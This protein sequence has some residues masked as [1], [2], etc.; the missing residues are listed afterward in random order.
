[1]FEGAL[2]QRAEHDAGANILLAQWTFDRQLIGAALQSVQ[3]AYGHYSRHDDSHSNA[4]L[5]QIGRLLGPKRLE[6]LSATDL[7]LLLE[8]AYSHDLGMVVPDAEARAWWSSSD[9][10]LYL[11]TLRSHSDPEYRRA[12]EN[13][14]NLPD[15]V[16]LGAE[17]PFELKRALQL[18]IAE[19]GRRRHA[20]RSSD[21]VVDPSSIGLDSPRALIP[22]RL[23]RVLGR[24]CALHGASLEE[25]M[26]LVQ[27]EQGIG[28]DDAHPRFV[29]C[30]LRIGDLLDV[31]DGRFC[32]VM[33]AT[34]GALPPSSDAHR[35]KH[36]AI[37]HLAV[38]PTRIDVEAV[39]EAGDEAAYDEAERWFAWLADEA[40]TL[41]ARWTEIS[42]R[43]S[44]GAFPSVGRVEAR[45]AQQVLVGNRRPRLEVD[46]ESLLKLM[47]G[48]N[49][50]SDRWDCI[51]ELLQ[52]AVDAVLLRVWE[53]RREDVERIASLV[54]S[55]PGT[56]PISELA[57]LVR[58]SAV[59]IEVRALPRTDGRD[60]E[61]RIW[62]VTVVDSGSGISARD[63][64]FIQRIGGSAKNPARLQARL[65][66]PEWIQPSGIFGIGLQSVFLLSD[67]ITLTSRALDESDVRRIVIRKEAS[68]TAAGVAVSLLDE[69]EL[70]LGAN[71]KLR[72][73]G[74]TR[75]EF[76][77]EMPAVPSTVS[78]SSGDREV[79]STLAD[80]DPVASDSLPYGAAKIRDAVRR[81]ARH[82]LVPIRL[83]ARDCPR[84]EEGKSPDAGFRYFDAPTS[85]DLTLFA[86]EQRR[87]SYYF[88][89][90]P[91]DSP[92]SHVL[93]SVDV[94]IHFGEAADILQLSREKLSADGARAVHER[95][96]DALSRA[97]PRYAEA[98]IARRVTSGSEA[99]AVSLLAVLDAEAATRR[100]GEQ[101]GAWKKKILVKGSPSLG[102]LADTDP[103]HIIVDSRSAD[104]VGMPKAAKWNSKKKL[105][106]L[107]WTAH[108]LDL[109]LDV[110]RYRGRNIS[111]Q[112]GKVTRS[113][114]ERRIVAHDRHQYLASSKGLETLT[115]SGL[116]FLLKHR[117]FATVGGRVTIP[118]PEAFRASLAL[119][120]DACTGTWIAS[121][122]YRLQPRMLSPY[123]ATAG[124][125]HER[126]LVATN[127]VELVQWV[128]P[129]TLSALSERET[130]EAYLAF[131]Q[132][133]EKLLGKDPL[134]S[135]VNLNDV[136]AALRAHFHIDARTSN[137]PAMPSKARTRPRQGGRE[138]KTR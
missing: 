40:R 33:N 30:M 71:K 5:L 129:R 127:M 107:P 14:A 11:E 73:R 69:H 23:F 19:Y 18:A 22:R 98:L 2:K 17:W 63:L 83:D 108:G 60:A 113:E 13:L 28:A 112:A 25:T 45:M 118:C 123:F 42:P 91:V 47:R 32:P 90:A 116:R 94:D 130:A 89:G 70:S 27:N 12:A 134:L 79:T 55:A 138:R 43:P 137:T 49:L 61:K 101:M 52:N 20:A 115:D 119:R 110:L 50:Y 99:E 121:V 65:R 66:M 75:V 8:A 104:R 103:L 74:G 6:S 7:W 125:R 102:I 135:N 31:D 84:A 39:C 54:K 124:H 35:R 131:M 72:R 77:L 88:R 37:T 128:A 10:Q 87:D 114:T 26:A 97:L 109:L 92:S 57:E 136:E 106:V 86:G 133:A 51:R 82:A 58:G 132:H 64:E 3:S 16:K 68:G 122:E 111:F 93:F 36:A 96:A 38:S 76:D 24:I 56:S 44:F 62:R 78:Q 105:L 15:L 4:I 29:A 34:F 21:I 46:R 117:H 41:A 48:S 53:E 120:D 80:Y 67:R 95:L 9:F 59:E 1:M 81:F 85:L 126:R 100:L